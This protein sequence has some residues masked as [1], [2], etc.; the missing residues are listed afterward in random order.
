MYSAEF[1][2]AFGVIRE[3]IVL[4]ILANAIVADLQAKGLL[5]GVRAKHPD[6]VGYRVF[7]NDAVVAGLGIANA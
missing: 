4:G 5:A 2:T 3:R 6:V 1:V 7:E